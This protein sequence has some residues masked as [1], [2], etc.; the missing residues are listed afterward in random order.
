MKSPGRLPPALY[1]NK[2]HMQY[3]IHPG[4]SHKLSQISITNL[5][6]WEVPRDRQIRARDRDYILYLDKEDIFFDSHN[7]PLPSGFFQSACCVECLSP[8]PG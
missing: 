4:L 7:N 3:L 2:Y 8:G 6:P 1:I 5:E